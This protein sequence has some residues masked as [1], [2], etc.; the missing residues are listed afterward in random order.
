LAAAVFSIAAMQSIVNL[1]LPAITADGT[2]I[3]FVASRVETGKNRLNDT[4][5]VYDRGTRALRT[6][7]VGHRSVDAIAWSPDGSRLAAVLD[8]PGQDAD[9]LF[10]IDPLNGSMKQLTD[11]KTGILQIAWSPDGSRIAFTARNYVAPARGEAAYRDAFE[12]SNNAYLVTAPAQPVHLWL[13]DL[14]GKQQRLTDG[15]WSIADAPL[16]WSPDGSSLLF[17]R[18][19]SAVYGVQDRSV[20]MRLQLR[21][22]QVTQAVPGRAYQDNALYSP[23]GLH[24]AYRS[25]RDGDPMNESEAFVDGR[26]ISAPLDRH[27]EVFSWMPDGA[28]LLLRVYDNAQAPLYILPLHGSARRVPL[29]PITDASIEPQGSV[30]ADG[31]IALVGDERGRPDELYVIAPHAQTPQRLTGFN[32]ATA[33]LS[34]GRAVRISWMTRD[35]MHADGILTYPPGYTPGKRYPLVL[36]IHGG[37]TESSTLGFEPFRQLAAAHGY[38]VFAPNYRGSNDLGNRYEHAIFNDASIGPGHD[39]MAGITQVERLGI[40]DRNRLAVSGWSYGGQLT[41]WMESQYPIWKA[42]VAGAAVNDLVVDYAI[43][44]DIDADAISFA[45]GSPYRGNFLAVWRRHS[46]ITY[47]KNIRTP[48]LILCNVYDVRVPIVESYEMYHA[49]R[50]NGV[51]VQFYAY[52]TSGHLPQGPVRLADAYERWLAWFDRYLH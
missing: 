47:F 33:A 21:A 11:G 24:V 42:A 36:R 4:L 10:L 12:V 41:S 40:V 29:G 39:I 17:E 23:D 6:L 46:P 19:P 26:N 2:K 45:G 20:V 44:D 35:G 16:S 32:D 37:P 34:L 30:A 27:V 48:T 49:L 43:A 8:V 15:A 1:S 52:P 14:A 9:Q 50:D 31:T 7:A 38:L 5:E 18:A 51:P 22:A 25:N 3:A 13:T 28:S